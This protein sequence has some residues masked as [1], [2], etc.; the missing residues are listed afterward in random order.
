[1]HTASPCPFPSPSTPQCTRQH[2]NIRFPFRASVRPRC[3]SKAPRPS[4]SSSLEPHF[5]NRCGLRLGR[6]R[7][8]WRRPRMGGKSVCQRCC[9]YTCIYCR[10]RK[11]KGRKLTLSILTLK[12]AVD[13]NS[14]FVGGL[15]LLAHRSG[16]MLS[17]M[18]FIAYSASASSCTSEAYPYTTA[19]R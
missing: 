7:A 9:M 3:P 2:L 5:S 10:W 11:G 4:M 19:D 16:N 13:A 12:I 17:V 6:R 15:L 8:S 14:A 18:S 1:M